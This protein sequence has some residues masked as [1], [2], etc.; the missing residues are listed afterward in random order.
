[1]KFTPTEQVNDDL[2]PVVKWKL[3]FEAEGTR[4]DSQ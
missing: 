2:E 3:L 1:M 4:F